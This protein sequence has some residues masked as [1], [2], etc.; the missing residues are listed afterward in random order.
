MVALEQLGH[1]P[2]RGHQ[3]AFAVHEVHRGHLRVHQVGLDFQVV[4]LGPVFR[5]QQRGGSAIGERGGVAGGQRALA[6]GLVE[7]GLERGEF[8]RRGVRAQDV[9]A[10]QAAERHHQV[11]E[12]AAPIGGGGILVR[13]RGQRV[14]R[15]ARDLPLPG[16]RLAVLAHGLAGA[17][18][19]HAR[20]LGLEFL[21]REALEGLEAGAG[22]ARHVGV[23]QAAPQALAHHDRHV[24]R[25]VRAAADAGFDL[26]QG[27]LV[28]HHDHGVQ[29]GAAG[30]LQRDARRGGRQARRQRG[31][32]AQVPVAAVLEHRAHGHFAQHFTVQLELLDQRA[33]RLDR[34]A[35][36]AHVVI[37]RVVAAEGD[38][39]AADDGD[40]TGGQHRLHSLQ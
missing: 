30:A 18:L 15:L 33:E 32:A 29:A 31:L 10:L 22:G 39:D 17:R 24:G 8:F 1:G 3:Q 7:G 13:R 4:G 40:T 9:V 16:H 14:L 23:E 28:R 26:P 35:Q 25:G 19:A 37:R 36:V 27:D 2:G 34:H 5:G 38:A 20:E 6:R 21:E 12:E 11:V